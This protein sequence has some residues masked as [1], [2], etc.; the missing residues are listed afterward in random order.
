MTPVSKIRY[1]FLVIFFSQFSLFAQTLKTRHYGVEEGLPSS[2][3]YHVLQD[4]KGYIWFSTNYGASRFDGYNFI[5]YSNIDGL[6]DNTILESYEDP[7]GKIWFISMNCKLAYFEKNK[8]IPFQFNEALAKQLKEAPYYIR[9][10]FRVD[11]KGTICLNVFKHGI[12]KISP[13]QS[14]VNDYA[15]TS[16]YKPGAYLNVTENNNTEFVINLAYAPAIKYFDKIKVTFRKHSFDITTSTNKQT[17]A[18]KYSLVTKQGH[19]LFSSENTL[20]EITPDKECYTHQFDKG[21]ISMNSDENGNLWIGFYNGGIKCFSQGNLKNKPVLHLLKTQTISGF[22]KD[23]EGGVWL[24]TTEKG[25]FYFPTEQLYSYTV[26]E[27][28][29]E[30]NVTSLTFDGKF[31]Y[32]I[33]GKLNKINIDSTSEI[34]SG[35]PDHKL[36]ILL[37]LFHDPYRGK[38]QVSANFGFYNFSTA[39]SKIIFNNDLENLEKPAW[40]VNDAIIQKDYVCYS[41]PNKIVINKN[42]LFTVFD[43]PENSLMKIK[44]ITSDNNNCI[45][46]GSFDGLWKLQDS[47]FVYMGNLNP[48]LKNRITVLRWNSA[49]KALVIGTK[50][51]GILVFKDGKIIQIDKTKGISGSLV[52]SIQMN[53]N[54]VWIGTDN[55]I[56][57]IIFNKDTI[58]KYSITAITG[59]N[60]LISNE[61]NSLFLFND[62]LFAGTNGGITYFD[63]KSYVPNSVPPPVYIT[64]FSVM[65]KDTTIVDMIELPYDKNEISIS[66]VGLSFK[67]AGNLEYRYML[68]GTNAK[69][70]TTRSTRMQYPKLAPG[71]Y[72]FIVYASNENDVWSKIPAKIRFVIR[73][74]FWQTVWFRLSFILLIIGVITLIYLYRLKI[75]KERNKLSRKANKYMLLSMGKQLNPHFIFNSLNAI[76]GFIFENDKQASNEYISE[77]ALLMRKT[78]YNSQNDFIPLA[79]EIELLSTYIKLEAMRFNNRFTYEISVD[80]RLDVA[81]WKIPPFIL[82]PYVE[83]AIIHGLRHKEGTGCL[84]LKLSCIDNQILCSVED[85]GIGREKSG[86]INKDTRKGHISMGSK[87]TDNRIN[88][89]NSL[90]HFNISMKY[91]DLQNETGQATGTRVDFVFPV[92]L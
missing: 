24:T 38:N 91:S 70:Q 83:N 71:D 20:K 26:K 77:F 84:I 12:F 44:S 45:Y 41:N 4:S 35:K 85:N 34:I 74:A 51:L 46:I 27:G 22:L 72:N 57:K 82:Q 60:G 47:K 36:L 30:D 75:I 49:L 78:L 17:S 73:P 21:V 1:L 14:I 3:I 80:P 58:E 68:E 66:Y 55:G 19:L 87:I 32:A 25:V 90:H 42:N 15:D 86:I 40:A 69:W 33:A 6:P 31:L 61:V 64:G 76:Q 13:D 16:K 52:T 63:T 65:Q 53:D 88:M 23:R 81:N 39:K 54:D 56:N 2:E 5:N 79:D 62:L 89:I 29:S 10:G 18:L 92:I 50:G 59:K 7:S 28:L 37:N 67:D 48:L 9:G 8:I 43:K 11:N